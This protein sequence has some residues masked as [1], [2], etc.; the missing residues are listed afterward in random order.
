MCAN[1]LEC[2]NE[3]KAKKDGSLS[4]NSRLLST[5]S[6]D[7]FQV[8]KTGGFNRSPTPPICRI[9]YL[10]CSLTWRDFPCEHHGNKFR[11][12][13]QHL[14]RGS[15]STVSVRTSR[16]EKGVNRGDESNLLPFSLHAVMKLLDD[17]I[18]ALV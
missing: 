16:L 7:Q 18:L 8:F 13:L 9:N 1:L 4:L 17:V 6:T 5:I 11:R 12:L 3:Q 2:E 10:R 14:L 15:L